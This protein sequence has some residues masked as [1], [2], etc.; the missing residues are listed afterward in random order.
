MTQTAAKQ[1]WKLLQKHDLCLHKALETNKH[2]QLGPGSEFRPTS[3]LNHIFKNHPL[4]KRLSTQLNHGADS[5]LEDLDQESKI[6]D[7]NDALEFG[8]H[9][10]IDDNPDLFKSMMDGDVTRGYSLVIPREK[11][12]ELKGALISPM[13]IANQSGINERGEIISKK[14]LTH[15]QSM[16]YSSGKSLNNRTIKDSFQDIMYST[17]LLRVLHQIVE[18][19]R[20][21]PDKHILIQKN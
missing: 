7:L 8:N 10:G 15:N 11:V 2:S 6:Q 1:N 21:Y 5:P 18:Y 17:C 13:N 19:R 16:E 12:T 20:R 9:K 14:R 4:W 3:T